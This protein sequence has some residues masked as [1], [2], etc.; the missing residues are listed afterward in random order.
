[1]LNVWHLISAIVSPF[2]ALPERDL[3]LEQAFRPLMDD[4]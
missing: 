1:M 4:H 2:W 3:M